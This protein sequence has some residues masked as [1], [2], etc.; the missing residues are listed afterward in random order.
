M[1]VIGRC[2]P[3]TSS[4]QTTATASLAGDLDGAVL[5]LKLLPDDK[6]ANER[7]AV[8]VRRPDDSP[9]VEGD[10]QSGKDQDGSGNVNKAHN[11][12]RVR[13]KD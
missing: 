8:S 4:L 10:V 11:L 12:L 7:P 3:A 2:P 6:S 13:P 1:L 5:S 9:V